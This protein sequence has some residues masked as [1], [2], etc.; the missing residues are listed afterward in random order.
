MEEDVKVELINKDN[1]KHV[2]SCNRI[3]R[4]DNKRLRVRIYA[5]DVKSAWVDLKWVGDVKFL[6]F[7]IKSEKHVDEIVFN[8]ETTRMKTLKRFVND[9]R[10]NGIEIEGL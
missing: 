8:V 6:M 2:Y 9:F 7:Y 5:K 1:T 3:R 4:N 10:K